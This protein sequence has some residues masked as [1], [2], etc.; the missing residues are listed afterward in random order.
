MMGGKRRTKA[1]FKCFR[2]GRNLLLGHGYEVILLWSKLNINT[3]SFPVY[4]GFA[5]NIFH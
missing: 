5:G 1:Q 4:L 3:G 2:H